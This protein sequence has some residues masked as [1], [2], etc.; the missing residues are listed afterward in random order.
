MIIASLNN[1]K[2]K[3]CSKLKEKKFRDEENSFLIE[4][5]HLVECALN[6]GVVK[7]IITTDENYKIPHI[8][9]YYVTSSI[10]KK[11]SNQVTGTNIIAVCQKI[12][13]R[14]IQGNVCL[15]D[16]IQDPGN[17][18]TIIRSAKAFGIDTLVLSL[19]TVDLYN[20][21]VIRASEGLLF[22]LNIIKADLKETIKKLKEKNYTIY[23]TNCKEGPE[24]RKTSFAPLSAII[25]GNEGR[26]MK[27]ELTSMCDEM[28]HISIDGESL[29][30]GVAASIIFYE[31]KNGK[32]KN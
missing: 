32:R 29:N 14:Q 10:M 2:V 9:V 19:D 6:Y 28:L 25:I 17:L 15:L 18:G 22:G 27:E 11:L 21:K 13:E 5:D 31:V 7:E 4:G 12:P 8:P 23:G 26:G 16:N 3:A 1:S 24:L 30:A 20:D